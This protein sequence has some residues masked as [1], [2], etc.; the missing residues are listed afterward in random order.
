VRYTYLFAAVALLAN[1]AA[2]GN[3]YAENAYIVELTGP[4]VAVRAP[5]G[6]KQTHDRTALEDARRSIAREQT[7]LRPALEAAGARVIA[8]VDTVANALIVRTTPEGAAALGRLPGVRH[9]HRS[10][11]YKQSLDRAVLL[12][13][14]TDAWA[15]LGGLANAGAG[16]KIGM[17]D[18]GIDID[19]PGFS[20]AGFFA[21]D[22]Y[23]IVARDVDVRF[24]N[25]KVI[26]ARSYDSSAFPGSPA[27]KKGH[28]TA[29]AMV[30]AGVTN[31]TPRGTITGIAP[32]AYLGNYK[33]F[34]DDLSGA[35]SELIIQALDDAAKDGMDVVNLSL[36]LLPA[37]AIAFD[38]LVEA[39]HNA[40]AAGMVVVIAA[41]NSGPDAHTMESP[42]T[43]PDAL[44]VANAANDRV[45]GTLAAADDGTMYRM[46]P[47]NGA[48]SSSGIHAALKDVS[49]I[50]GDGLA[51]N[52]LPGGSL[53]GVIALIL[54]GT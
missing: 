37:P 10:V 2:P 18:T 39:I 25:N 5:S 3:A 11:L 33:V 7:S 42:G 41:G 15:Q 23:P 36:G 13:K 27:D 54:R 35:P 38:P 8:S 51:C 21:P 26:V 50:D 47:G 49:R 14:V 9:I 17:I 29:T 16:I 32:R 43:A 34:P 1:V 24:T 40:S 4:P 6:D 19:H 52:D 28:G 53:S 30:A 44:T 45:F 31:T 22:G 20:D 48:N 12:Q 46:F